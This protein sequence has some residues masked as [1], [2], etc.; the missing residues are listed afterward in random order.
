MRSRR[1]LGSSLLLGFLAF[2]AVARAAEE[3]DK[4]LVLDVQP[5]D[6]ASKKPAKVLSELL[7][8]EISNLHRFE[9]LGQSDLATLTGLEREK[10]MLGC[11]DDATS[12][13]A[14]VAGALGAPYV[15]AGTVGRVG[16]E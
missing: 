12:C 2:S 16:K 7:L 6:D 9:V 15:F 5:V 3:Q 4:I 13:M 14:E 10:K 8:T 11:S 1:W